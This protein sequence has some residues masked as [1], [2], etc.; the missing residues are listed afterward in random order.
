[1]SGIDDG[2]ERALL[3]MQREVELLRDADEPIDDYE[4]GFQ[5]ACHDFLKHIECGLDVVRKRRGFAE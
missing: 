4:K 2:E 3:R 5:A 1:M